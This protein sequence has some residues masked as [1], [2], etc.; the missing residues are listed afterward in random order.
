VSDW[1]VDDRAIVDHQQHGSM[2]RDT[3]HS[4]RA[5]DAN[6]PHGARWALAVPR[7]RIE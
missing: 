2:K 5:I 1:F 7:R 6:V 4:R 3:G